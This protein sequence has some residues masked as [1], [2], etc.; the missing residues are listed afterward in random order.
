[1]LF[2]WKNQNKNNAIEETIQKIKDGD[3]HLRETF[4]R[5]YG[6]FILKV[7][8][9]TIGRFV[10]IENH[11][12]YS[13][14]L[15]AFNEAINRYDPTKGASFLSFASQVIKRRVI[16]LVRSNQ[17][18]KKV[19]PF[20]YFES[21]YDTGFE[22]RYL[23]NDHLTEF[24]SVEIRQEIELFERSLKEFDISLKDLANSSPKHKDSKLFSIKIAKVISDSEE[25]FKKLM[26]NKKI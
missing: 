22:E 1:M 24:E 25:M 26:K 23:T 15:S 10:E 20:T 8:S 18:G 5:H 17:S 13:I 9:N 4:I 11:E 14:A 12:E 6:P 7:A 3:S 21:E 19:Y 16:D 2:D